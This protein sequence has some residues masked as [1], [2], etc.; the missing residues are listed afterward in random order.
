MNIFRG[1]E[2]KNFAIELKAK[3]VLVVFDVNTGVFANGVIELLT[4]VGK[5]VQTYCFNDKHLVPEINNL[6][7]LLDKVKDYDY[8]LGVG[9][10]T[11]NDICKYASYKQELPYGIY[12]TAPSMD[13]YVSSVSALYE[14]GKKV[15]LPTTIPTDVLIQVNTLKKAPIEMIVAGA[16]DMVGKYTSLL[17]WKFAHLLNGEKYDEQIVKRMEKAVKICIDNAKELVNRNEQ[18]VSSLIEGLILSGIEMQNAGNSRPASGCEHHLSHYLEMAAEKLNTHFAPHGVQVALGSIVGNLMYRFALEKKFK[19]V[20]LIE[21][22]ILSLPTVEW[23]ISLYEHIGLPT[24]FSQIGVDNGLLAQTIQNAYTV[25]E[26]F[27]VMTF[28]K[29]N[30]SLSTVSNQIV[31]NV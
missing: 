21:K 11:I 10:G 13:G 20:E 3:K 15:T 22:D 12:A 23:L 6:N 17:D 4:A 31:G 26:R 9:S 5:Q 30:G 8:L 19:G 16:G 14:N 28:L 27:T 2:I 25:R 1:Q 7:E 18:A 24:K 29:D